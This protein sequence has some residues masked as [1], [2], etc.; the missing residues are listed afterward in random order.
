MHAEL[1]ARQVA[2]AAD[3]AHPARRT[4]RDGHGQRGLETV[5]GVTAEEDRVVLIEALFGGRSAAAHAV[6]GVGRPLVATSRTRWPEIGE[7]RPAGELM[8]ATPAPG[9]AEAPF[10]ATTGAEAHHAG[11][12]LA[13]RSQG[14]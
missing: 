9:R 10:G 8:P 1:A 6:A 13:R 4:W 3:H 12:P 7:H 5:G 11:A 2:L 14:A